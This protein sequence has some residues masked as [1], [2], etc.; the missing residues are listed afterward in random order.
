MVTLPST[1][2]PA[3]GSTLYLPSRDWHAAMI[4]TPL[5]LAMMSLPPICSAT[6]NALCLLKS[7]YGVDVAPSCPR[8]PRPLA[9]QVP[10]STVH[11]WAVHNSNSVN[12]VHSLLFM[13]SRRHASVVGPR[14]MPR[15]C[16]PHTLTAIVQLSAAIATRLLA[17]RTCGQIDTVWLH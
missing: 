4:R 3:T 12:V 1:T 5:P 16:D 13:R 8:L 15:P 10:C 7:S 9:A 6:R 2:P 14:P 11:S 17:L